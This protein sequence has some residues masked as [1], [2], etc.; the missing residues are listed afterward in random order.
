MK[1]ETLEL[2]VHLVGMALTDHLELMYDGMGRGGGGGGGEEGWAWRNFYEVTDCCS[3]VGVV[4][5][6]L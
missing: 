5:M 4:T 3:T 1:L 6:I 2:L